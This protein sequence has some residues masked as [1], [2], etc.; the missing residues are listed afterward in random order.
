MYCTL[1]PNSGS[2]SLKVSLVKFAVY[3]HVHGPY[4]THTHRLVTFKQSY[5]LFLLSISLFG[6]HKQ[7]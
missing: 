1:K 6:P 2:S 5:F 7:L 3:L 4:I